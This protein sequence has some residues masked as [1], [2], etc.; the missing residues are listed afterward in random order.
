MAWRN[1]RCITKPTWTEE[2]AACW[3]F[4]RCFGM[5]DGRWAATISGAAPLKFSPNGAALLS[6]WR[7]ISYAWP[8][9]A[10]VSEVAVDADAAAPLLAP[11]L[12]LL[13]L[14]LALLPPRLPRRCRRVRGQAPPEPFS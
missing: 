12:V 6:S 5:M 1:S 13:L 10:A 3:I 2:V 9:A 14:P 8:D 4:V 7:W 11:V